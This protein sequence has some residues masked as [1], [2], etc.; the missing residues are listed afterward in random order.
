M[1]NNNINYRSKGIRLVEKDVLVGILREA[2]GEMPLLSYDSWVDS[3]G[4]SKKDVFLVVLFQFHGS[5]TERAFHIRD[6]FRH[7]IR[8]TGDGEEMDYEVHA[9][10]RIL[11]FARIIIIL[12][13]LLH[14]FHRFVPVFK[15]LFRREIDLESSYARWRREEEEERMAEE[16]EAVYSRFP[17]KMPRFRS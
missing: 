10:K 5:R 9:A 4:T 2:D 6:V 12:Q 14:G 16:A 1:G 11:R 15:E 13:L 7:R 17:V 8:L 3:A